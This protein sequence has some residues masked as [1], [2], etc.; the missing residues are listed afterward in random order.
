MLSSGC[1]FSYDN[2]TTKLILSNCS[3]LTPAFFHA[4]DT[5]DEAHGVGCS[6]RTFLG[7]LVRIEQMKGNMAENTLFWLSV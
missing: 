3:S 4:T 6:G 7:W 5:L 1:L 2:S